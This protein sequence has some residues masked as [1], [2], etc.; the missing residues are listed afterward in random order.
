MV[1][2]AVIKTSF[3]SFLDLPLLPSVRSMFINFSTMAISM[4]KFIA[5]LICSLS[6]SMVIYHRRYATI[7][8]CLNVSNSSK[9]F[10]SDVHRIIN[11]HAI[12]NWVPRHNVQVLIRNAT[13]YFLCK[14]RPNSMYRSGL[15]SIRASLHKYG[16][17]Y[18]INPSLRKCGGG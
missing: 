17:Y 10:V 11:V 14:Y 16:R 7:N 15:T 1:F 2:Q 9:Q 8:W 12:F 6:R 18:E 4:A 5:S 3:G 13:F